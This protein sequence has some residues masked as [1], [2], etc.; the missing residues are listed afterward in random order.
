M[1]LVYKS[2][3][4]S[5]LSTNNYYGVV[6][7]EDFLTGTPFNVTV[8][9]LENILEP[10]SGYY[11]DPSSRLH[12]ETVEVLKSM[13]TDARGY[14]RLENVDCIAAYG[15]DSGSD[16]RNLVLVTPGESS[17]SVYCCLV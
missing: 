8:S 14:D 5:A 1:H 11:T 2:V 17:C 4:F 6:A 9:Y 16:R 12:Q 13:Q 10:D 7:T 3:I 15:H